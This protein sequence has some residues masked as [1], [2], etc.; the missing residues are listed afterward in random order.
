MS[1]FKLVAQREKCTQVRH[2]AV[3]VWQAD[4]V[5]VILP[6]SRLERS[7]AWAEWM[8]SKFHLS[9]S[10]VE[11]RNDYLPQMYHNGRGLTVKRLWAL[12]VLHN[13]G[14]KRLDGTTAAMRLFDREFPYLFS[15]LVNRYSVMR[16]AWYGLS[17]RCL[18]IHIPPVCT[19]IPPIGIARI[20]RIIEYGLPVFT[21]AIICLS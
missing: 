6:K 3:H 9:P 1:C 20:P 13:Y 5:S 12:T 21:P 7:L 17:P 4:T 10:A 16:S 8:A 11:G 15:W 19:P 14:F 2:R 18:M